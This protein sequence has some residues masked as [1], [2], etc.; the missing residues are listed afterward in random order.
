[1]YPYSNVI[2]Y[3]FLTFNLASKIIPKFI[4]LL[5][6]STNSRICMLCVALDF[7]SKLKFIQTSQIKVFFIIIYQINFKTKCKV[8]VCRRVAC[9]VKWTFNY[10]VARYVS[11]FKSL[12]FALNI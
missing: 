6:L 4:W 8:F 1:M 3:E 2:N 11:K 5:I 7:N 10:H 12:T 9:L